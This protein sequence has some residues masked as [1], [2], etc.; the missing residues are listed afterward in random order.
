[1][2]DN[3]I[4]SSNKYIVTRISGTAIDNKISKRP[5]NNIK[6][7]F[8]KKTKSPTSFNDTISV[9]SSES[10]PDTITTFS[11]ELENMTRLKSEENSRLVQSRFSNNS[12][13]T[14]V[15]KN[16]R[17]IDTELHDKL[18]EATRDVEIDVSEVYKKI[19]LIRSLKDH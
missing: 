17:N 4:V 14:T 8:N 9:T 19:Q 5:Y 13:S 18:K 12:T 10:S 7:S 6:K 3:R 11:N 16:T 1:M 2:P 15:K